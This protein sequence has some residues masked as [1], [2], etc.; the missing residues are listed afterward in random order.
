M[1]ANGCKEVAMHQQSCYCFIKVEFRDKN[2]LWP[3]ETAQL[4]RSLKIRI[5][6]P[7][8]LV[9]CWW[10]DNVGLGKDSS[11]SCPWPR[12][13]YTTIFQ[14]QFLY[15][16]VYQIRENTDNLF[17]WPYF[18]S[19]FPAWKRSVNVQRVIPLKSDEIVTVTCNFGPKA[20][21]ASIMYTMLISLIF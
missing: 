20:L 3:Y 7:K 16:F 10:D 19:V 21:L 2:Y 9:Y 11:C 13:W 8:V 17:K 14:I 12:D 5:L 18:L 4:M 1:T 6:H 15:L